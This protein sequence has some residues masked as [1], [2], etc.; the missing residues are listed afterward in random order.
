MIQGPNMYQG[1]ALRRYWIYFLFFMF[2][3]ISGIYISCSYE[4]KQPI[5][6]SHRVH[7]QYFRGG[8]HKAANFKLH[9]E[10]LGEIPEELQKGA[11][12][13]CHGSFAEAAEDFP[14]IKD[15]AGC[16]ELFIEKK[17]LEKREIRPCVG[18]HRNTI[19]GYRASL[20]NVEIC[21]LC[22]K[23]KITRDPEEKKLV[24]FVNNQRSIDWVR[25]NGNLKGDTHFSHSRHVE[26]GN[27]DCRE[28]HG[29][30]DKTSKPS[31]LKFT[32]K[33]EKCMDCHK[34]K[35]ASNDCLSCHY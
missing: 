14:R 22:H 28:C 9:E 18:C 13:D 3:G 6:F 33:M 15:C 16:H 1:I 5:R 20:P 32:V 12:P 8:E 2:P 26:L 34:K 4:R 11:C 19:Q 17:I 25:I 31:S 7:Y 21:S 30:V 29:P 23:E 35:N 10:S 27:V 24:T